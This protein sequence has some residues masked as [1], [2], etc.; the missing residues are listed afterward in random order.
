MPLSCSNAVLASW[1]SIALKVAASSSPS[2]AA[3]AT[4]WIRDS[5]ASS[6]PSKLVTRSSADGVGSAANGIPAR[7]NTRPCAW[8]S[9]E[10]TLSICQLGLRALSTAHTAAS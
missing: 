4:P 10:R 2:A 6:M 8:A 9:W 7:W 5:L 3:R 1:G